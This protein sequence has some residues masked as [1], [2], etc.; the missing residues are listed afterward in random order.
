MIGMLRGLWE[1]RYFVAV[2]IWNDF[3]VRFVR[4]KLGGTWLLLQPLSQVL[5]YAFILSNLLASRIPDI[6]NTYGYAI[7][8]MAGLLAWN[9]FSE[10]IDRCLKIFVNNANI[11]KKMNFPK[12]T[13]P[14]IAVGSAVVNNLVLLAVMIV[15]F[16][17]LGHSPGWTI[18][19]I[20]LLL[21]VVVIFSLGV[22]LF[23]G[24]I[25]VFIRDVEQVTPIV[26]QI[27]FWFT[28]IVY[29]ITIVPQKYIPF[30]ELNPMLHMVDAYHK[31]I[32]YGLTPGFAGIA[33]TAAIG[34]V[35]CAVSLFIFRRATAEMVDVL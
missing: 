32:A 33:V 6:D 23:L 21:P 34:L 11:I 7:Y 19:Y 13:L 12:V 3:Y 17:L 26:L 25:N 35:M 28:P 18:P 30:L 24:V 4:S 2:S 22:G 9:L 31:T 10:I 16:F 29:P 1:Y 27:L 20:F 15:I 8:L 5:I 14:V